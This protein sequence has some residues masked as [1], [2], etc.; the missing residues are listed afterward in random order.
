MVGCLCARGPSGDSVISS[1]HTPPLSP[2]PGP[3][4]LGQ[5]LAPVYLQQWLVVPKNLLNYR[6]SPAPVISAQWLS[7]RLS[8]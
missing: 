2:R 8:Q 1:L 7:L 3:P 6:L 5:S 4:C